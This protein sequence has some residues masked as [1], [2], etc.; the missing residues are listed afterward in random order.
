LRLLFNSIDFAVFLPLVFAIY[1]LIPKNQLNLQNAF[2]TL[3]S[4][5]FYGWWDARFLGLMLISILIDFSCGWWMYTST[6]PVRRKYLLLISIVSNLAMLGFFKYY[7]FFIDSFNTAFSFAGIP[8]QGAFLDIILPVGISFYTFQTLSYTIDIYRGVTKP[9]SDFF[10]FSAFVSFF[11]QLVAG[12]IE[13]ANKLIPQFQQVRT[14]DYGFAVLGCK[15]ILWGFFKKCVI[16]DNCAI[17]SDAVFDNYETFGGSS[18]L[19]GA[20]FFSFQIYGDFSGY[21]DIAIGIA[22]LFGIS[23]SRNFDYPYFS[24]NVGQFWRKWHISL[25]SWFRDYVYIPLGGNQMN[26]SRTILNILVVFLLSGFWHGA[27]WN[28][29][30]WGLLHGLIVSLLIIFKQPAKAT[31]FTTPWLIRRMF[32]AFR[33]GSTF[34]LVSLIWIFFRTENIQIAWNIFMKILSSS[35]FEIPV[36]PY[37]GIAGSVTIFIVFMLFMEWRWKHCSFPLEMAFSQN[38]RPVRWA[39]YILLLSISGLSMHVGHAPFIYFQF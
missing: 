6:S 15:Q 21:T 32:F 13:K 30:V 14:F 29:V 39:F 34:L 8:V 24:E 18:L 28:F 19:V 16:A 31:E 17:V 38:S 20:L 25:S 4:F 22:R 37:R 35:L 10:T 36:F 9:T 26:R 27:R 2:V 5:V 7:N 3:S 23:L 11:P 33:I 12:P 1:W